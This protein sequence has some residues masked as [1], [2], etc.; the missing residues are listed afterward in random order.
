MTSLVL[1]TTVVDPV[2]RDHA[3]ERFRTQG[4]ALPTF[5]QLADPTT[6]PDGVATRLAAVD[7]DDADPANLFRVHWCNGA[8]RTTL[9]DVPEHLVLPPSLT[10]RRR[11]DRGA[12]GRPLPDDRGPQGAGRLR[13]PRAADRHRPVR[14]HRAPRHLAVDRQLRPRRRG[15]LAAHGLPRRRRAPRGHEPG[16]LRR[17][18]TG[19]VADPADIVRTPGSESNV[20]EIYDACNELAR[21][22]DE[23]RAQPVLRVR[24][25]PRPLARSPAAA[26]RARRSS[27]SPDD[28]PELRLARLRV[29]VGLGRHARRGRHLKQ[30]HGAPIVAVEALECPTMLCNGFGEHNIQGI[31]DKHVPLIHNVMGHRRRRRRSPTEHRRARC[32]LQHR[33]RAGRACR[34]AGARPTIVAQLPHLGPVDLQP[35][36]ADQGREAPRLGADDLIVTVATD[37]AALYGSE[38]EKTWPATAPTASTTAPPPRSSPS[39]STAQ[40][41]TTCSS[42]ASRAR[43]RIFN[44]GYF[45]WVEQ[46]GVSLE[47]FEAR[48]Q[49]FWTGLEALVPEWDALI[50]DFNQRTGGSPPGDR[51]AGCGWPAPPRSATSCCPRRRRRRRPRPGPRLARRRTWPAEATPTRS[52]A[53]G[54]LASRPG[55]ERRRYFG[56]SSASTPRWRGGGRRRGFSVTPFRWGDSLG[57]W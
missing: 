53:T 50:E 33:R 27:G 38:R 55:R 54:R 43:D 56:W 23:R 21:D 32:A 10:R 39:T 48:R 47:D 2:A 57:A 17:G 45:T 52:C 40:P 6:F 24:E 20:K 7:P 44:L 30:R 14:S 42:S 22:P 19:W 16:A 13:V 37:G 28:R 15:H 29:G 41:P 9:V 25:P 34:R 1:E 4:I 3:V 31:G 36:R 35:R 49:A 11:A 18:W 8:D 12:A 51:A 46:Q 5:A 26:L